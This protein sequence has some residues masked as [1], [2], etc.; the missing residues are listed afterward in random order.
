MDR[1]IA[2]DHSIFSFINHLPHTELTD[3]VGKLFSGV[4]TSIIL[5]G[6]V[7]FVVF[8]REEK[9]HPSFFVPLFLSLL[10]S[11]T[12]VEL[13]MK[14]L[15]GRHRPVIEMGAFLVTQASGYSFPSSHAALSWAFA[16]VFSA[17]EPKLRWMFI[18]VASIVSLS[19]VYLGVHFPIDILVGA[20]L[21]WVIGHVALSILSGMR[22][23]QKG[24]R[25]Q[26]DIRQTKKNRA[27]SRTSKTVSP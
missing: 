21:G 16:T 8:V 20:V 9:K 22:T 2:L 6:I 3:L 27:S 26:S 24:W 25:G 17:Y 7:G 4:G 23:M 14:P 1:I 18:L 15:L 12:I 10:F 13:I 5:W 19:R 11:W